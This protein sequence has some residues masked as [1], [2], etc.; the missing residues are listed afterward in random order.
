[1]DVCDVCA[2]KDGCATVL[3]KG[4]QQAS[5][6]SGNGRKRQEARLMC[7]WSPSPYLSLSTFRFRQ[8]TLEILSS[9]LLPKDHNHSGAS[10]QV[11]VI[12]SAPPAQLINHGR[13]VL[14]LGSW[15]ALSSA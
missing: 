14:V 6:S 11:S 5:R 1:M 2:D 3:R 13:G 12:S 7:L 4:L 15:A 8:G 10:Q 9:F